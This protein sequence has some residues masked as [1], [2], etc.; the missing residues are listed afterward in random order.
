MQLTEKYNSPHRLHLETTK[1][2]NLLC[3]HC[4]ISASD[5]FEHHKLSQL[6]KTIFATAQKGATR[7]TFTG[8]EFLMHPDSK[9]LIE[10]AI[11]NGY[12]NIYFITN[13]IYLRKN[14]L[15]WLAHLKVKE[16]LKSLFRTITG[17]TSPLTI[18]LG[19]S[20]DGLEG[21][22][23]IRK[24]KNG[25]SVSH[26][27][28]L[29]K[30]KLATQYGLYVTVNTTI[31]NAV[32]AKELYSLYRKLLELKVDRWQVD[33]VFMSGRSTTSHAVQD[34]EE[35]LDIAKES[36][37]QIIR[38]YLATYPRHTKM[39]LE[40]VQLFRSS[41][42]NNGFKI[43]SSDAYHPCSYQFG[44]IIVEGGSKV[45]FCPSLRYKGD[46]I[47]NN[48]EKEITRVSYNEN[49]EFKIFSKITIHDLPCKDC[50][51]KF[52]AHGGCRGNSVSYSNGLF[53]KDPVCCALAPFLEERIIPLLPCEIQKQYKNAIFNEGKTP[54]NI[55]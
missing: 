38:D 25:K 10:Y 23:L 55:L 6:K 21:N 24:Y 22:A 48:E 26:E 36:Y 8:G 13:G 35:W 33:Q 44:S 20:L 30:I 12:R 34:K 54:E 7:I 32:T 2:C 4:Y 39:R 40:I 53:S 28:I 49:E 47:F 52:I 18:G 19:I 42:L 3:E 11:S 31:C 17:K 27:K 1:R 16:T 29:E 9:E 5:N 50:R 41:I 14:I 46:V 15:D 45:R 51:Y 37:Y 43:I